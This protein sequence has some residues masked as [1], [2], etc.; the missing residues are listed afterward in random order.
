MAATRGIHVAIGAIVAA[1]I[2]SVMRNRIIDIDDANTRFTGAF[3]LG[4]RD[5]NLSP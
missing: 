1:E 3:L 5:H 2:A 4:D